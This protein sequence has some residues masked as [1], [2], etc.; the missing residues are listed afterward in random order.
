ME[1]AVRRLTLLQ[2]SRTRRRSSGFTVIELL[3]AAA[4]MTVLL[5]MVLTIVSTMMENWNRAADR[6]RLRS[7]A[8]AALERVALELESGLVVAEHPGAWA[9]QSSAGATNFENSASIAAIVPSE[10]GAWQLVWYGVPVDPPAHAL[11]SDAVPGLFRQTVDP[12]TTAQ[13][14]FGVGGAVANAVADFA[15]SPV[16]DD[17]L[18]Q[19]VVAMKVTLWAPDE[20]GELLP[21]EELTGAVM[22]ETLSFPLAVTS[23]GGTELNYAAPSVI[24]V[25]L[26]VMTPEGA[27]ELER[28]S[29]GGPDALSNFDRAAWIEAH[30]EVFLRRITLAAGR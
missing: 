15:G 24:E 27:A 29:A 5:G 14:Y 11:L 2:R 18:L 4:I 28:Q 21:W 16:A 8:Q 13:D 20:S 7:Q 30:S 3:V 1:A 25:S 23:R 17:I 10:A 12:A 26:R 9:F 6:A 22:P 19:G